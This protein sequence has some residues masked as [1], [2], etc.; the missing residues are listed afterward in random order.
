MRQN[1]MEA[2]GFRLFANAPRETGIARRTADGD[3]EACQVCQC[4]HLS[5]EMYLDCV[6][7]GLEQSRFLT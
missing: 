4:D 2:A 6:W 3:V 5:R 7:G 1:L